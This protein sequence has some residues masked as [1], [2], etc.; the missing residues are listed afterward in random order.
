[1]SR[2]LQTTNQQ[3]KPAPWAGWS[4]QGVLHCVCDNL[5]SLPNNIEPC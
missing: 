3:N 4:E 2:E 5:P 1:M